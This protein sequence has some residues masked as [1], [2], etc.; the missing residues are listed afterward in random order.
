MEAESS[1][2]LMYSIHFVLVVS[3]FFLITYRYFIRYKKVIYAILATLGV[4][5]LW[6]QITTIIENETT[7]RLISHTKLCIAYI[8][9]FFASVFFFVQHH[10]SRY[11]KIS[12]ILWILI[13]FQSILYYLFFNL[14]GVGF[15]ES[16]PFHLK[17]G[18]KGAGI[19]DFYRLIIDVSSAVFLL[20]GTSIFYQHLQGK[21]ED[22]RSV[23]TP[24]LGKFTTVIFSFLLL[25]NPLTYDI[26]D[27]YRTVEE[28]P[29][30]QFKDFYK[31]PHTDI[32]KPKQQYNLIWIYAEAFERIYL[33]DSV[34][35]KLTPR[36]TQLEKKSL[37]FTN[38]H[39]VWGT[40][41]TIAGI[42]ASQCGIPLYAV[43]RQQ[44]DLGKLPQFLPKVA[45]IGNILKQHNYQCIFIQ[46][47]PRA[48]AGNDRYLVSHGFDL[49]SFENIDS[50]YKTREN[51][52]RWGLN[53]DKTFEFAKQKYQELQRQNHP[54]ALMLS[55]INTHSPHG[56]VPP[57]YKKM[58]YGNGKNNSLNAFKVSDYLI[59]KFIDDIKKIDRHNNTM[60]VVSSDHLTMKNLAYATLE[61]HSGKRRNLFMVYFPEKIQPRFHHKSGST[62]DEGITVLNLMGYNIQHLG[63]GTSLL[64]KQPSLSGKAGNEINEVLKS[65]KK[66]YFQFWE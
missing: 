1:F 45:G 34:F 14:T 24:S 27:T 9:F 48:F 21:T 5:F 60:I 42:V 26:Y 44:N 62:L 32:V 59:S 40:G 51:I 18:I 16:I 30:F 15:N 54:F 31:K 55:T 33:N 17:S 6:Q 52:S 11:R 3:V 25:L 8:V 22:N 61:K 64:H 35:P 19:G 2:L 63:F 7:L 57:S 10:N 38:I 39:Q 43:G 4:W 66:Y 58:K 23:H 29:K 28:N 37:S 36:L 56:F 65:W 49:F 46:G 41:W 53:D 20:I 12:F 50:R 13:A 47:S